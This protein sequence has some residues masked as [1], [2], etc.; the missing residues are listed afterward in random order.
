MRILLRV[1]RLID[2]VSVR[3][4]LIIR[5]LVLAAVLISAGNAI[6]RKL[7]QTSS[8]AF[9]EIQWYLFAGVFM[10][11]AGYTFLCNAHVRI[12]F[13]S[14]HFSPRTRA[15]IDI[16]GI[17]FFLIPFCWI[18]IDLGWPVFYNAW[19]SGE[20][21]Q[22]AGGLIRW[23]VFALLPA[24]VGLLLAQSAS[25][26]VKRFAFLKGLIPDPTG[27]GHGS[28]PTADELSEEVAAVRKPKAGEGR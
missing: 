24:G 25:E 5:W 7:F 14:A 20:M 17:V 19:A 6:V 23:P 27:H 12:D 1:S 13:V 22:N 28:R 9:L 16:A 3:I 15:W 18:M 11:G 21:S 4:G 10:L 26:L 8:N 2:A